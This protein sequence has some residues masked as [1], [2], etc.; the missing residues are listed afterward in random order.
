MIPVTDHI[1]DSDCDI[2]D[3]TKTWLSPNDQDQVIINQICLAGYDFISV[4]RTTGLGGGVAL[5]HRS[6]LKV[7]Q[8]TSP[9]NC[10]IFCIHSCDM[11]LS[12]P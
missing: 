3:F 10:H 8:Q 7:V 1:I 12:G 2:I 11:L 5:M 6:S 9:C 4:P